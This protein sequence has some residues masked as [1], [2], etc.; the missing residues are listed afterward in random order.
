MSRRSDRDRLADI[1]TACEAIRSYLTRSKV[2]DDIVYDAIRARLI[3]IGEAV[4]DLDPK[5]IA[6]EPDIP[7]AEIARMRDQL[8]HHYFDTAHSIVHA[9]AANDVP[10]L[11]AAVQRLLAASD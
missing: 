6:T 5:L 7:W 10:K 8:T 11:A 3:E 4:K 9:T 1:A 2:G